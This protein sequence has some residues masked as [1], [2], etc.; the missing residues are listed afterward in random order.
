MMKCL[1]I[2]LA[3]V[4]SAPTPAGK[5]VLWGDD[6]GAALEAT[7][8]LQKPLLIVIDDSAQS[9]SQLRHVEAV[10]EKKNAELL[11]SYVL[12]HVDV[13]TEYG[14]RVAEVFEVK[15]YPFTAILDKTGEK[16]IYRMTG[17]LDDSD[18]ITALDTHKRGESRSGS[19]SRKSRSTCYT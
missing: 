1:L 5:E 4:A 13:T 12:C 8:D 19:A 3:V 16:I 2:A 15:Q 17:Q 7:K 6:Y 14:K 18:W 10:P 11:E 9:K